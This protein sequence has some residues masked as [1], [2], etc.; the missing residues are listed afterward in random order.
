MANQRKDPA[1]RRKGNQISLS[2]SPNEQAR[3]EA[4][5]L[6]IGARSRPDSV[7]QAIDLCGVMTDEELAVMFVRLAGE[8]EQPER[9]FLS[10]GPLAGEELP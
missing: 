6:R 1:D 8:P 9:V 10:N 4:W 7:I 5:R 2:L 3:E